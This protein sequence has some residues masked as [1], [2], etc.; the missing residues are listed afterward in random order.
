[1]L[2]D[3][4]ITLLFLDFYML[5]NIIIYKIWNITVF[6]V[7]IAPPLLEK[8]WGGAIITWNTVYQF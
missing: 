4:V 3:L 2:C 5:T 7:I 1:M 8:K 6:H